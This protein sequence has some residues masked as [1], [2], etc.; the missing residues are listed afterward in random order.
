ME[1]HNNWVNTQ[2]ER[3]EN[4]D[5]KGREEPV[6]KALEAHGRRTVVMKRREGGEKRTGKKRRKE[7]ER[8]R[9]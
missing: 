2:E 1:A 7:E 6:R 3:T 4:T 8:R 9:E 5:N